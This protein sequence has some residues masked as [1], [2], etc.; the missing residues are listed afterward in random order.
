MARRPLSVALA[1]FLVV[2]ATGLSAVAEE[3]A[4]GRTMT[5][6]AL[7][8]TAFRIGSDQVRFGPLQFVGGLRLTSPDRDFG[9]FSSFRFLEP[10]GRFVGVADT[11]FWYFG[12]VTRDGEGRPTGFADFSIAPIADANGNLTRDKWLTDAESIAVR[13]DIATVGFEREHRISEYRLDPAGM[14][15][16]LRDLDFLVPRKELRLNKGFE[17]IAY[18]P[19]DGPLE[20]ARVAV[21]EKSIDKEGNSFAAVLEGPGKGVFFVARHDDFDFTDGAFLPGGDLL[22]LERFYAPLKGVAMR[23]RHIPAD[24]IRPGATAE[25]TIILTADMGYQIDNMEGLDVWRRDD[26]ATMVSIVSDDNQSFLQ[27]NLY[28]EFRLLE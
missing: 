25:G 20:G 10:G 14:G 23:L 6:N 27:R 9:S 19:E 13:G 4:A 3:P 5:V 17:T 26:G 16:K 22:L 2:I 15:K 18:A 1:A 28:L 7:P 12:R 24:E 11:G 8:I 21:T